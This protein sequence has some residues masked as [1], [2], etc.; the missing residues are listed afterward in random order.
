MNEILE[1]IEFSLR[2]RMFDNALL[3]CHE[4]F[5][6]APDELKSHFLH[7]YARGYIESGCPGQAAILLNKHEAL[8]LENPE[9]LLLWA[10]SYFESGE[11]SSAEIV[12]KKIEIKE[13]SQIQDAKLQ[14]YLMITYYYLLGQIKQRTHRHDFSKNHFKECII[15]NRYMLSAIK[16]TDKETLL[17]ITTTLNIT[18][19][20]MIE[21]NDTIEPKEIK[22]I[23]SPVQSSSFFSRSQPPKPEISITELFLLN[24]QIGPENIAAEYRDNIEAKKTAALFYFQRSKYTEASQI[25]SQLFESFPFCVD[26]LDIYS[27]VLWQLKD[28]LTL[29]NLVRNL[30]QMAP[31]CPEPWIAA[32]NLLSLNQK[33]D[34]AI[35]MFERAANISKKCS[36]ALALAGQEYLL[37]EKSKEA[38]NAF[39]MSIDRNPLEWPAWYG[40]GE[41]KFRQDSFSAAEYYIGKAFR[42]N[43]FSSVLCCIYSKVL[44]RCG[45]NQDALDMLNRSIELDPFNSIAIYE[46]GCLFYEM[47]ELEK[48]RECLQIASP[49]AI[50]EPTISFMLGKINEQLGDFHNSLS[51]F[52]DALIKGYPE[53]EQINAELNGI[54]QILD[55][56]LQKELQKADEEEKEDKTNDS[57]CNGDDE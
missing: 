4:Y 55:D 37:T 20:P 53:K 19:L 18:Q 8:I 12:L 45:R 38:E 39:K 14:K 56:L 31:N 11:Y 49:L 33:N 44:K 5:S 36:Y 6:R 48:A 57:S 2:F 40:L 7:L 13:I 34:E 1:T 35:K 29:S 51:Y 10:Q 15:Q 26:G 3:L 50:Q 21:D 25:Y 41:V 22:I 9:L 23:S 42:L 27:T 17:P 32:G 54:N 30:T 28:T 16:N 46:Q 47:G 52:V 43:P 24:D